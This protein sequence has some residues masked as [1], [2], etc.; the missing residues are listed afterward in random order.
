MKTQNKPSHASCRIKAKS[1]T[2]GELI[3]ST[4]CIC[5][6]QRAPKILQLA[7]ESH[8]IQFKGPS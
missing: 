6:E 1:M 3:A 7:I 4:Y 5:G 8:L 2:L